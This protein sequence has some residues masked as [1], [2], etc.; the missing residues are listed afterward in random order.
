MYSKIEWIASSQNPFILITLLTKLIND[1]IHR[2]LIRGMIT[3][4]D[5]VYDLECKYCGNNL[6]HF[7]KKNDS[8]EC[9]KCNYEQIVWK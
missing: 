4:K 7:P 9:K 8:I 5:Q 2:I 1:F 6:P 3:S